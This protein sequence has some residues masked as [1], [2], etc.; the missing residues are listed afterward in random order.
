M[1]VSAYV[2]GMVPERTGRNILV[3]VVYF[4]FLVAILPNILLTY[5]S[6]RGC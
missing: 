5:R 1:G 3:G 2:P 4:V 6:F